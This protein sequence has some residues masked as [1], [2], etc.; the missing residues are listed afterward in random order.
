MAEKTRARRAL[1]AGALLAIGLVVAACGSS[2]GSS[3]SSTSASASGASSDCKLSEAKSIVAQ[4]SKV[5]EFT[6][7]GPAFDISSARG[8]S[9]LTIPGSSSVPFNDLIDRGMQAVAEKYGVKYTEYRN[10]GAV[11]EWVAGVNAAIAH[12]VDLL[13][14][15]GSPNPMDLQPQ[16]KK[17]RDAGI[18][19]LVTH[20]IPEGGATSLAPPMDNYLPPNVDYLVEAPF[21]ASA[22]L[23]AA[24]AVTDTN[25][26][27]DV[28]S[29]TSNDLLASRS[30]SNA[31]GDE[32]KRLCPSCKFTVLDIPITQW[33]SKIQTG[34]QTAIT[35]DPKLNYV[36]PIYDAM[37]Q[38]VVPGVTA[39]NASRRVKVATYNGTPFALDYIRQGNV[40]AMD[41]GDNIEW[42][43]YANMD[44]AF[45]ILTGTDPVQNEKTPLRIFDKTNVEE[46][47]TPA[48]ANQGYGNAY[49]S[50]YQKLWGVSG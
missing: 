1:G 33:S 38:F 25:C 20:A 43:S 29:V 46:A 50:G 13:I 48:K 3:T 7:P 49:I 15:S 40:V 10:Q 12:K 22:K 9:I 45:R 27:A 5:P 36:L 8:K 18:K 11:N 17:A 28:L 6:P 39:A 35:K 4:Y 2:G 34:V 30:I 42:N 16:L 26:K 37:A 21:K 19:V 31:Q 23:E 41:A 44:Q 32:L 14:L 47:G 24:Y